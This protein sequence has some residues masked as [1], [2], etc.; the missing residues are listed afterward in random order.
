MTA[1][2][3]TFGGDVTLTEVALLQGQGRSFS[4]FSSRKKQ[5]LLL[6]VLLLNRTELIAKIFMQETAGKFYW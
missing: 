3:W 4:L 1:R 2:Y 5:Q 6:R